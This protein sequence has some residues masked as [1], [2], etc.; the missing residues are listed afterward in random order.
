MIDKVESRRRIQQLVENFWETHGTYSAYSEQ[1]TATKWIKPLLEFLGWDLYDL[2]EVRE[3]VKIDLHSGEQRFFDCILYSQT[4]SEK[5]KEYIVIEFKRLGAG[6]LNNKVKAV[7]K[8][9][10]NAK[11]TNAKYAVI[12]R[13]DETIIYDAK[14]GEEKAFFRSPD[15]YLSEFETLWNYLANPS[16]LQ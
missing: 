15:A 14:T 8:L 12:T 10:D 2:R 7:K 3:G 1:D 5:T 13:F 9:K 4:N 6:F 11:E 16:K